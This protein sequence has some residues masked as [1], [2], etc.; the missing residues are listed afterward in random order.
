MESCLESFQLLLT[1]SGA[2]ARGSHPA[3]GR[4]SRQGFG[5]FSSKISEGKWH[6]LAWPLGF[7]SFPSLRSPFRGSVLHYTCSHN[8]WLPLA[9]NWGL[10]GVS[11]KPVGLL[12]ALKDLCSVA[13]K[14]V[15]SKFVNHV[16]KAGIFIL[17]RTL[18]LIKKMLRV[19]LSV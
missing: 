2:E 16:S 4:C 8:V 13:I 1:D 6:T 5:V 7:T 17:K 18:V 15:A 10:G 12:M 14:A 11:W 19:P 9:R 3:T